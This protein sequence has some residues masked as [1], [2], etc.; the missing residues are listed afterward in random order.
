[1]NN[2]F[3]Y[4][5]A[6]L[7]GGAGVLAFSPF[8]LWGFAYVSLIGLLFVIKNPQKKTA[9]LSAFL[10]GLSFFSIGVSWLHVSIH[11]FGGS[12]LWLSYILVVALAAY[13][14]LYPLLFAYIV[15]RFNVTSLVIFPVIWTFT[16]FLRGWIFTGFPWLQFGYTQIDSPFYGIAPLFGVTGL[17][18]FV[19]WASAVIFSGI[20]ALIQ[21]P[22]KLPVALV[23]ALLLLSV[24]G[25]AALSSQKIFVK[26]VPEKAITVTLAQGN[27]EQNLKW[28]PQYLYATLNI[29]R[30]LIL[31]HLA[32][33]DLIVLPESALPALENQLQPFYQALQTA[34][35]EKG[36]EVLIG[37][38]YHD[39]KS[40]KLL[41]SIVS[42]GNSAQPY[43]AGN[44]ASAM[45]YSKHHL[46]PFG[47][48][49]PLEN[50]LRPL[51]SVFNLPMSAFQSGDFIQKPL[52]AKGRAL[53]PAICYEIILGSQLQQ[54]LQPNT[55]FLLT[56]S[57]D[58]W[59]GD[60][61]GPWQ[62]LQMARM[63]ALELGKPLIRATNTGISV[64]INAQ[65]K[66]IS[67]A[68]QFEQTALTEKIAPTEGKTPYAALGD[69]PLYLLAFIFV[70]LRVLAIFIKRKVLKSAV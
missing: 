2:I 10:W 52:L 18:F 36:T 57:N 46:V 45:R 41:N 9:L 34:T 55:D 11:Q 12:P 48:Y 61:I 31:E 39:E 6:I 3:T 13:L 59:F 23:N 60:S 35:Q 27:I 56:V 65:G 66:V 58:A 42:V 51:G 28:D 40:D 22:K 69:K 44:A 4:I 43:Q 14:S 68:P 8:D 15:R 25:L 1:M 33:S 30:K 21:T 24:G 47:E 20:S 49:V 50:L 26:E 29:Y 32:T 7:T 17:T 38:V 64:F 70:M 16:E 37:S 53:T 5:I 54:N 19:M 62:H 67:Q 63:R